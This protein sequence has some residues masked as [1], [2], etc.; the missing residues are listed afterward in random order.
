MNSKTNKK[1]IKKI[2]NKLVLEKEVGIKTNSLNLTLYLISKATKQTNLFIVGENGHQLYQQFDI[3]TNIKSAYEDALYD[4]SIYPRELNSNSENE[5]RR[6]EGQVARGEGGVIFCSALPEKVSIHVKKTTT[7]KRVLKTGD[8]INKKE[9]I[10]TALVLGY[11]KVDTTRYPGE[12]STRGG[13][14]DFFSIND[15]NPTRID[16]FGDNIDSIRRYNPTSQLSIKST[17]KTAHLLIP[18][19]I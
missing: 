6:V 10:E 16:F 8:K 4:K 14:I 13:V 7:Q 17:D 9:L 2:I 18:N 1:K 11:S 5:V 12:I 19:S 3:A 15:N